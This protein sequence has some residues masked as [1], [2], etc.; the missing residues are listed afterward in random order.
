ME[1]L[2]SYW[3]DFHEIF[4]LRFFAHLS[5]ERIR[6]SFKSNKYNGHFTRPMYICDSI[7]LNSS[8]NDK[9]FETE[10][11]E[12]STHILCAINFFP[13]KSCPLW[14]NVEKQSR[15]GHTTDD[16]IVRRIRT[17]CCITDCKHTLRICN[18]FSFCTAIVVTWMRLN[19]T[20]YVHCFSCFFVSLCSQESV[21]TTVQSGMWLCVYC[22]HS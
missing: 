15:S 22:R 11:V 13:W 17:A 8:C 20:L 19:V 1:L 6:V 9:T 18:T 4:L 16:R 12:K 5:R 10:V 2:G 3:T 14:D 7:S 21:N